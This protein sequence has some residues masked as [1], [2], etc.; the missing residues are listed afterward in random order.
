MAIQRLQDQRIDAGQR[1]KAEK[2]ENDQRPGGKP[3]PIFKLGRLGK[4]GEAEITG[5]IVRA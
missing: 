1:H 4:I 3:E 2:A 5:D